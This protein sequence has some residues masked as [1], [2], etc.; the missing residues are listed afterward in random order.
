M[1]RM[2]DE[3]ILFFQHRCRRIVR[4]VF[5]A[6]VTLFY[7]IQTCGWFMTR[8]DIAYYLHQD[9]PIRLDIAPRDFVDVPFDDLDILLNGKHCRQCL[10]TRFSNFVHDSYQSIPSNRKIFR[11]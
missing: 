4:A 9:T 1:E 7:H 11:F 3:I 10:D 5:P 6:D 8:Q 2:L